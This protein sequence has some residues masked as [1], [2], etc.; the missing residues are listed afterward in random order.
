MLDCYTCTT[1]LSLTLRRCRR[2]VNTSVDELCVPL[3]APRADLAPGRALR[4]DPSGF[5][6]SVDAMVAISE[7]SAGVK[8]W[9]VLVYRVPSE[10]ASRLALARDWLARSGRKMP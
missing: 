2:L 7:P 10:P 6:C 9:W 3:G 4:I 1:E 5:R 8:Q